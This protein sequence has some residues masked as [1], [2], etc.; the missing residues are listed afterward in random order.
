MNGRPVAI[1][2]GFD[3]TLAEAGAR[4]Q[5]VG[6]DGVARSARCARRARSSRRSRWRESGLDAGTSSRLTGEL[7]RPARFRVAGVYRDYGAERGA[8]L[9]DLATLGRDSAGAVSP[10]SRST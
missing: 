1:S 6:G 7:G 5:L 3:A 4:V 2:S 9:M 8:V 10:T